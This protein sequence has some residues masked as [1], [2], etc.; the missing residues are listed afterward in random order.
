MLT[1]PLNFRVEDLG[2]DLNECF[3]IIDTEN[4]ALKGQK[5]F[6]ALQQLDTKA[7]ANL[8]DKVVLNF[9]SQERNNFAEFFSIIKR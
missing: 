2:A 3:E 1:I 4:S 7:A 8:K 9:L 6:V 5:Q